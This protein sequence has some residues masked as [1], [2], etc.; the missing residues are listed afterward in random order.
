[1]MFILLNKTILLLGKRE[2]VTTF[3]CIIHVHPWPQII[4]HD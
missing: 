2:T 4:I 3:K 1:M